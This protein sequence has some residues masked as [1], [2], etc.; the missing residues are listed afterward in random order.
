MTHS[1]IAGEYG[2]LDRELPPI[3]LALGLRHACGAMGYGRREVG[4]FQST[5]RGE[6]HISIEDK[7][8]NAVALVEQHVVLPP[9]RKRVSLVGLKT[10]ASFWA[11][12]LPSKPCMA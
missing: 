10:F 2:V 6:R 3:C 11:L 4:T 9:N 12:K 8:A 1:R 7:Q 5:G